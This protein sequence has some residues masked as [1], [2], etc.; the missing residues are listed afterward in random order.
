M[1]VKPV[2]EA[3]QDSGPAWPY[4]WEILAREGAKEG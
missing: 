3:S 2:D 4:P 1:T